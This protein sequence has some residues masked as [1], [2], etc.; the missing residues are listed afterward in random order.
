MVFEEFLDRDPGNGYR[1][2]LKPRC[3]TARNRLLTLHL[4]ALYQ[5][6]TTLSTALFSLDTI[7]RNKPFSTRLVDKPVFFT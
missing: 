2:V 6:A 7:E 3:L 4:L 5:T 1:A